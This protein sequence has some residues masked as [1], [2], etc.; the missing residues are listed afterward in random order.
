[1]FGYV[2]V[3]RDELKVKD[4]NRY[5][6]FY[7]GLCY[8]LRKRY[9]LK[10]Q[11]L[12]P[13]D[14]TFLD[15]L[16]NGL[17]EQPLEEKDEHCVI[18]PL[19]KQHMVYNAITDYCADMGILL[20]Y[21]KMLDDVRDDSSIRAGA[22]AKTLKKQAEEIIAKYPRQAK[23]VSECIEELHDLE[24]A[25]NYD[26]DRVSGQTGRMI[27]EIFVMKEDLWADVLRKMGF[28]LGKYIYLLDAYD[29]LE[30]DEKK[31][32]YNPWE[33]DKNRPDFEA[34]V[35]NTLTM[36]MAECARNFEKLPILQDIDILRNIVY[37]GVWVKYREIQKKRAKKAEEE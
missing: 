28:Y 17:Y 16:L 11:L 9:G 14:L 29:D 21:Y 15:V 31:H 10:G 1:M 23:A 12:L 26:L 6:S 7:C 8:S 2:I 33:K 35:E 30:K 19:R 5:R 20:A 34:L 4:V 22:Y 18:H 3:N 24:D 37:S 25:K 36:M 27:G 32:H 13:N